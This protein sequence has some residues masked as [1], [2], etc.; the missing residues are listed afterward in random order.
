MQKLNV[1]LDISVLGYGHYN[2]K[3]RTGVAR[4]IERLAHGLLQSE[5]CELRFAAGHC[6]HALNC[7]VGYLSASKLFSEVPFISSPSTALT[8]RKAVELF[9]FVESY[10]SLGEQVLGV[11]QS[12]LMKSIK[13]SVINIIHMIDEKGRLMDQGTLD[14]CQIFHAPFYEP[15]REVRDHKSVKTITTVHDL[16]PVMLPELFVGIND[17]DYQRM[18]K[19]LEA[20]TP[21]DYIICVSQATKNDL[22]NRSNLDPEKVFVTYEAADP[23]MFFAV[24]DGPRIQEVRD[25]YGI[26]ESPYFLSVCTLEPRKN[27][28][29]VIEAFSKVIHEGKDPDLKLVLVGSLGWK[30]ERIFEVLNQWKIGRDRVILTGYVADEDLAPLYSQ[31]LGFVYVSLYEGFGLPPLEAM[32]C[33]TPTITSNVSSLPEVVG[34]AAILVDPKD[35][36]AIAE[37][38]LRIYQDS[39]FR[40]H[41]AQKGL[42]RSRQFTWQRCVDETIAAY[43]MM[44]SN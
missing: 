29:R 14:E 11:D 41:L 27:L 40:E 19:S 23:A 20:L 6:L 10:Q 5:E 9:Q 32:Q 13:H 8:W 30:Y 34:D 35:T 37:A 25:R 28:D 33:G 21:D 22:I 31:A 36:N 24:N 26:S 44:L 12:E 4:Y 18:L 16:I 43:Q 42:M 39:R 3:C 2:P 17:I 7:T 38:M 15:A 1:A